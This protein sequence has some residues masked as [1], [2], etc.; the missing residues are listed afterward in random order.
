MK[1]NI[2]QY[3]SDFFD[4]PR[5]GR[6]RESNAKS[7]AQRQAE[8]RK[9]QKALRQISVTRNEKNRMNTLSTSLA[10]EDQIKT[11]TISYPEFCLLIDV[12]ALRAA[13]DQDTSGEWVRLYKRLGGEV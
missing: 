3:T 9:R 4:S 8:Y 7:S 5:R 12:V 10:Q 13:S 2:D 6:P 1:Q 11:I